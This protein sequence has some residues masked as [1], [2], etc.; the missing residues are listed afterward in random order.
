[1]VTLVRILCGIPVQFGG[2]SFE[3][4]FKLVPMRVL[5]L[6]LEKSLFSSKGYDGHLGRWQLNV[7]FFLF[8]HFKVRD[9][10]VFFLLIK[11]IHQM[12]I[13]LLSM[14]KYPS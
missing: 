8:T 4:E 10:Y 7:F 12:Y 9:I 2:R 14:P 6:L 11:L 13:L 1:M 5:V 3:V